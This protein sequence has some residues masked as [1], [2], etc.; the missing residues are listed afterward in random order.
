MNSRLLLLLV[1]LLLALCASRQVLGQDEA[2]TPVRLSE[3]FGILAQNGRTWH[4]F[5]KQT[6]ILYL[7]GIQDGAVLL[8]KELFVTSLPNDGK[9]ALDAVTISGFRFSDLVTQVDLFYS[10]SANIRVAIIEAYKYSIMKMK[11]AEKSESDRAVTKLR[12][13]Y[14]QQP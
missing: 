1:F 10:D 8:L 12:Q 7:N 3:T 6:K 13:T 9:R 5:D 4:S 11:G 14:N 2:E